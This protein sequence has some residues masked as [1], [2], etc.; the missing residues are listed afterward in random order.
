MILGASLTLSRS[1]P[2]GVAGSSRYAFHRAKRHL[3]LTLTV[4][5]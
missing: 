5:I 1:A 3:F 4:H 2:L